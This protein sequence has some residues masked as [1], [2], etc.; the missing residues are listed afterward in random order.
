MKDTGRNTLTLK[1]DAELVQELELLAR[2]NDVSL[3]EL[4]LAAWSSLLWRLTGERELVVGAAVDGSR[5]KELHES[6]GLFTKY[7]P[8]PLRFAATASFQEII[9]RV[10]A[11]YR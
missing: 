10:A 11:S 5:Y 8:V 6:L 4:L 2:A 7:L 9:K 3:S 1:S